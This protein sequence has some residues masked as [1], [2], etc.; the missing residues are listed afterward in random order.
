VV[1][2]SKPRCEKKIQ[3]LNRQRP[4][5][6]FLPCVERVHNYGG[7]HR[8]YLIPM[9]TGY[10]FARIRREDKV[11][12][13]QNQN[14]AN[15]IEVLNEDRFLSPLRAIAEALREGLDLEVLP[16][17]QP[18]SKVLVTGGPLKG[19]EAEIIELKGARRVVL[20][21]EL[22]QKSVAMEIDVSYLKAV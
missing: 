10:V 15:V 16:A 18:G 9:F 6:I 1:L 21:L 3:L 4:A 2:H 12:F 19:L 11:W 7:R 13:R 20:H 14:V 5:H 17:L 22:I 8:A